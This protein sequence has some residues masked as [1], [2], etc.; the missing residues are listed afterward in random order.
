MRLALNI[1][2]PVHPCGSHGGGCSKGEGEVVA[3]QDSSSSNDLYV[4]A[5][6]DGCPTTLCG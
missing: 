4:I 3:S 2:L 1:S 5:I 6:P